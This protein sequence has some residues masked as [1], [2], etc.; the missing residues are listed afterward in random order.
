MDLGRSEVLPYPVVDVWDFYLS[1]LEQAQ[2]HNLI[3]LWACLEK[4]ENTIINNIRQMM[5]SNT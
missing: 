3:N 1:S 2:K 5:Q 4:W